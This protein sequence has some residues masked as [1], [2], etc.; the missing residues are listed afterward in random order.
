MIIYYQVQMKIL[1]MHS[2]SHTECTE[3]ECFLHKQKGGWLAGASDSPALVGL[4]GVKY[5]SLCAQ[6]KENT[7]NKIIF[8]V[9]AFRKPVN[10]FLNNS[11]NLK[12]TLNVIKH[13]PR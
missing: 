8:S 5:N 13:S 3:Q 6:L 4:Q 11:L 9:A 12:A 7:P 1:W 10:Y 2:W